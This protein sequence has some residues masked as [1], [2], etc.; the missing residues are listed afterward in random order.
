MSSQPGRGRIKNAKA[1]VQCSFTFQGLVALLFVCCFEK[2][3]LTATAPDIRVYFLAQPKAKTQKRTGIRKKR[4]GVLEK[5]V[6][7]I[8]V[9]LNHRRKSEEGTSHKE[10]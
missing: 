6:L 1:L 2:I 5:C 8:T 10:K 7:L 9:K 3:F 4:A